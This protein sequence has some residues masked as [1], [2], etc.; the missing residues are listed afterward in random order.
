MQGGGNDGIHVH[1]G[2]KVRRRVVVRMVVVRMVV[3]RMMR[4]VMM[5]LMMQT[6]PTP[7]V[8]P[9]GTTLHLLLLEEEEGT[10]RALPASLEHAQGPL[11]KRHGLRVRDVVTDVM[12]TT[13]GCWSRRGGEGSSK[14]P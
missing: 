4:M 14:R 3:V 6:T 2:L 13:F 1:H 10:A 8:R 12:R 7:T 5:T 11:K 9:S